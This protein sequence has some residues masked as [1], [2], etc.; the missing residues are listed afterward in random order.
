MT[1]NRH[2]GYNKFDNN[3]KSSQVVSLQSRGHREQGRKLSAQR[4]PD[5]VK[6]VFPP[7]A[8]QIL[9]EVGDWM[10][11]NGESI[12]GTTASPLD[13]PPDWGRVTQK[14]DTFYLHILTWPHDGKISVRNLPDVP[15]RAFLLANRQSLKFATTG[16][17]ISISL[18]FSQPDKTDT[19]IVL[20]MTSP[21][22]ESK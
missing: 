14:G 18:P 2:W 19:V 1:L 17:E 12:Y 11:V 6:A 21:K 5:F 13:S 10:K 8:V 22:A 3:W 7:Q 16:S 15:T 4:G 9:T 20:E